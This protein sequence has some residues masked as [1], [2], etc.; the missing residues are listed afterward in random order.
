MGFY[1]EYDIELQDKCYTGEPD[2][3]QY[4]LLDLKERLLALVEWLPANPLDS[5]YDRYF[6]EDHI[7]EPYEI[8][9]TVQGLLKAIEIVEEKIANQK[10][11]NARR[12]LFVESIFQTGA[13]P[14]GQYVLPSYMFSPYE[15]SGVAA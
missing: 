4:Q 3:L 10:T 9:C 5:Y 1:S 8:P 2:S 6:Y 12:A 13:T 15:L 7:T 11:E 14:N